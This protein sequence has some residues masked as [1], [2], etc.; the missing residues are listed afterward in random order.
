MK[1]QQSKSKCLQC[2]YASFSPNW[3]L[4]FK[5][6]I[7]FF[8]VFVFSKQFLKFYFNFTFISFIIIFFLLNFN[9]EFQWLTVTNMITIIFFFPYRPSHILLVFKAWVCVCFFMSYLVAFL[10]YFIWYMYVIF[11]LFFFFLAFLFCIWTMAFPINRTYIHIYT[12]D[13]H[14]YLYS[15]T[16]TNTLYH[17]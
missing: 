1:I 10:I 9:K 11:F 3:I 7:F 15:T 16:Y 13:T 5:E 6:K 17:R 12:Q 14:P 8:L 4:F 2:L